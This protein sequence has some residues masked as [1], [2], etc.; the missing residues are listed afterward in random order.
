MKTLKKNMEVGEGDWHQ[1]QESTL[2]A[3]EEVQLNFLFYKKK[4]NK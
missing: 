1:L 4:K 2:K 3:K